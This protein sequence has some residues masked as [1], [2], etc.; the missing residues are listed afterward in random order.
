VVASHNVAS[1]I[2]A[3][4]EGQIHGGVAMG[5]GVCLSEE[6]IFSNGKTGE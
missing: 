1:R 5:T 2:Q 4:I 6:V 3:G